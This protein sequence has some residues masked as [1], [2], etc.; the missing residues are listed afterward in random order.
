MRLVFGLAIFVTILAPAATV[1]Q[2]QVPIDPLAWNRQP[3]QYALTVFDDVKSSLADAGYDVH[4]VVIYANEFV[5]NAM[6]L[7]VPRR[8]RW[9]QP[10]G[11]FTKF[12]LYNPFFMTQMEVT[13]GSRWAAVS[14]I[15]HEFGHHIAGH[16]V[17]QTPWQPMRHPWDREL[18]ADYYAGLCLE[19]LGARP[20]DLQTAQRLA[21]SLWGSPTHP[22]SVRRIQSINRGWMA[23]GG[24]SIEADLAAIWRNIEDDLTKWWPGR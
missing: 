14:I 11:G 15:A 17:S 9:S 19:Q 13:S 2:F 8:N 5:P 3:S 12:V 1:A 23:A 7:A 6:A 4:D 21:F 22:D 24:E 16:T 18:E 20:R 10:I